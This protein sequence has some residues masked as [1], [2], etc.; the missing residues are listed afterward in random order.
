MLEGLLGSTK[1]LTGVAGS[2]ICGLNGFIFSTSDFIT[3]SADN[4]GRKLLG[5]LQPAAVS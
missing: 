2:G 3:A 5:V 4:G 1:S